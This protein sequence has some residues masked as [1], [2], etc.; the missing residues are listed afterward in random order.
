LLKH[1][2]PFL[3][4]K[5]PSITQFPITTTLRRAFADH[6]AQVHQAIE[7]IALHDAGSAFA[8]EEEACI[9]A[10]LSPELA[11]HHRVEDARATLTALAQEIARVELR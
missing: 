6:L 5:M 8:A 1:S 9:R 7:T 4:A 3:N 2:S 11:L 10:V